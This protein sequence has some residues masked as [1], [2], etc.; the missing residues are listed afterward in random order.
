MYPYDQVTHICALSLPLH[1]AIGF[2]DTT[3]FISSD[4]VD[5]RMLVI[6][7]ADAQDSADVILGRLSAIVSKPNFMEQSRPQRCNLLKTTIPRPNVYLPLYRIL[8]G[9]KEPT[10]FLVVGQ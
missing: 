4:D 10:T 5:A 2:S 1:S 8:C 9:V 3:R 7:L 6:L